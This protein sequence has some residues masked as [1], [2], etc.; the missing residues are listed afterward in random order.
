MKKLIQEIRSDIDWRVSELVTIKTFPVKYDMDEYHI[1]TLIWYSIPAIYAIWQGFI[2]NSFQSYASFINRKKLDSDE[3]DMNIL[4]HIIDIECE[5][6]NHRTHFDSRRNLMV[7]IVDILSNTPIKVN[8]KI[9]ESNIN[10]KNLNKIL[11]RFNISPLDPKFENPLDRLLNFRNHIAHGENS[12]KVERKDIDEFILT[13][14]NLMDEILVK[15]T[16]SAKNEKYK[17]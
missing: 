11:I 16:E 10:Y 12:I 5:M 7:Q 6:N 4:T 1:Q 13:V 15:I 17:F 3:L 14:Q 9:P 2:R 8:P